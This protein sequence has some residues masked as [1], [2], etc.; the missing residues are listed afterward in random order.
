MFGATSVFTR[1]LVALSGTEVE[2]KLAELMYDDNIQV[3]SS[4]ELNQIASYTYH[5]TSIAG[6]KDL[7]EKI[8]DMLEAVL[9]K[10]VDHSTLTVHK[11]LIVLKHVLVYG[12]EK[13]INASMYL[14]AYVE[15][16]QNYNTAVLAQQGSMG[17]IMRFKG[18]A[19]DKGG[20]VREV[21]QQL[22]VLISN[23]QQLQYERSTKAD[24]NSL[25]PIGSRDRAAFV[26]DEARLQVLKR[27]MEQERM[28]IA[29]SNLAK[30]DSAFGGGYTS[31]DGK[32]V[33]GAAHGL[34]EMIKQARKEK[35]KFSDEGYQPPGNE[36]AI[37]A[38]AQAEANLQDLL[39]MDNDFGTNA[40][41]Q[42]NAPP[43]AT[44][45]LLDFGGPSATVAPTASTNYQNDLLGVSDWGASAPAANDIFG[46]MTSTAPSSTVAP[47]NDP[48]AFAAA[49]VPH[50]SSAVSGLVGTAQPDTS[51]PDA[52]LSSGVG[53]PQ[54]SMS[55]LNKPETSTAVDRFAALDALA[56]SSS[57]HTPA[58]AS[59]SNPVSLP[60][61]NVDA[62]TDLSTLS[63]AL[64]S[65]PAISV[66]TSSLKV[67][68][69]GMAPIGG[70]GDDDDNGF[71]MGGSVGAGLKPLGPAP[72]APPPPPPPTTYGGY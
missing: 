7:C 20:P 51:N 16:L 41:A 55:S 34:D 46:G 49:P 52:L 31:K 65:A 47:I 13:V 40:V 21:A 28:M 53:M 71:V 10:P 67:S 23:R 29:K 11:A 61:P 35:Q 68:Q 44:V 48:F 26:T 72:A 9:A 43:P 33:V 12:A 36:D 58:F 3:I 63:T 2:K 37:L 27:R 4:L 14:G 56:D 57:S 54:S 8:L 60:T 66:N 70:N 45:D 18:G 25:V 22:S 17:M 62:L 38:A 42:N 50:P 39:S 64:P 15:A 5:E 24:P 69:L 1:G 59:P 6:G 30:S 19:V 32:H